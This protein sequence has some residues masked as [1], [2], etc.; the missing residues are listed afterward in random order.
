MK[1]FSSLSPTLF[2][3]GP[4]IP[5]ALIVWQVL[6]PLAS[7]KYFP[8]LIHSSAGSTSAN[9]SKGIS[10]LIKNSSTKSAAVSAS[11]E[12]RLNFGICFNNGRIIS[13]VSTNPF[14]H[15]PFSLLPSCVNSGAKVPPL[16]C[17]L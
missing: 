2:R 5:P 1:P 15:D 6:H 3:L 17:I 8:L 13:G 11:S 9:L 7:Y 12:V 4:T 16:P 10:S 14:I